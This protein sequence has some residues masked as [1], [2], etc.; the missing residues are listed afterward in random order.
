VNAQATHLQ[1]GLQCGL[2]HSRLALLTR[3][4]LTAGGEGRPGAC[5]AAH[6][7]RRARRDG[8]RLAQPAANNSARAQQRDDLLGW[9]LHA[10]RLQHSL[11]NRV[12]TPARLLRRATRLF[13]AD[14]LPWCFRGS[15]N[16]PRR[17]RARHADGEP[18]GVVESVAERHADACSR[19]T[20]ARK[21]ARATQDGDAHGF[22]IKAARRSC[23]P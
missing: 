12:E 23:V 14:R 20:S 2:I 16:E 3:E 18:P 11:A 9:N 7:V 4:R 8:R 13:R 19:D 6:K 21:A 17:G 10:G 22:G 15:S 5:A 1:P